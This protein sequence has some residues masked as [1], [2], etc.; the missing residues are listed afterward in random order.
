V[1]TLLIPIAVLVALGSLGWLGLKV[2]PASFSAFPQR[3]P[4]M[5][6]VPLPSDLPAPVERF[7]RRVYG[8]NVPV[9]ESAVITGRAWMRPFGPAY[10]PGRFRFTHIAGRGY[11]HY[12]EVTIFGLPLFKVNERY[13]DGK[14]LFEAPIGVVDDDP[15]QNQG[16][17]LGMWSESL[18]FP[19][20]FLSDPRV[21]WEPVDDHTAV[22]AVPFEE[23]QE[24]YVVRFDPETGLISYFESMRYHGPESQSKTLWLNESVEW[25]E[26][27]GVPTLKTGAAIWLDQRTPWAIF[28]VE[29]IV[30]NVDVAEYIWAKGE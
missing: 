2:M 29:D 13:L 22:L 23:T 11:R 16:A 6:T 20:V 8:D 19:S 27:D 28:T 15:K 10:L 24:Q 17:N 18:W 3:T 4:E 26:F 12:I 1:K 5:R 30:Y 21:H 14:S 7:Y 25:G 9:V